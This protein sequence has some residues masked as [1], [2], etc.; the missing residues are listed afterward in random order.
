MKVLTFLFLILFS[1]TGL[2]QEEKI[3]GKIRKDPSSLAHYLTADKKSEREKVTAIYTYVTS[4]IA[5]DYESIM[6]AKPYTIGGTKDVLTSGKAISLTYCYLLQVMLHAVDIESSVISGY[7]TSEYEDSL[8]TPYKNSYYWLSV[9]IDDKWYLTDPT[10]DAGYIGLE[11]TNRDEK[12]AEK[13]DK[14]DEKYKKKSGNLQQKRE[15]TMKAGKARKLDKKIHDLDEDYATNQEKLEDDFNEADE[16][17]D[18]IGFIQEP[19]QTWFLVSPDSFLTQ[20]LPINPMWQLREDTI[21]ILE[22]MGD[23]ETRRERIAQNNGGSF[24]YNEAIDTYMELNEID[25]LIYSAVDGF[26]YNDTN[27]HAIAYNYH[28]YLSILFSKD[29]K[30]QYL[31]LNITELTKVAEKADSAAV[32]AKI[33]NKNEGAGYKYA[34]KYYAAKYKEAKTGNKY[35]TK[36]VKDGMKIHLK[37]LENLKKDQSKGAEVLESTVKKIAKYG[38]TAQSVNPKSP[39]NEVFFE[40]FLTQIDSFEVLDKSYKNQLIAWQK[41]VDTTYL[42]HAYS[43]LVENKFLMDQRAYILSY[44]DYSTND[45]TDEMDSIYSKNHE[46]LTALYQDSLSIE[47]LADVDDILKLQSRI[48]LEVQVASQDMKLKDPSHNHEL[49]MGYFSQKLMKNF[50]AF[51]QAKERS[52]EHNDWMLGIMKL[53]T[54]D[55]KAM[56]KL[57]ERQVKLTDDRDEYNRELIEKSHERSE[58]IYENIEKEAKAWE[59][60]VKARIREK[61]GD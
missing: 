16:F 31:G 32:F 18:K 24:D 26:N 5:Y 28:L 6:D 38:R 10:M 49:V 8:V 40:P 41:A 30:D 51:L 34:K 19:T 59:E 44:L 43:L 37:F 48:A 21:S 53:F 27:A 23:D 61:K 56:E 55:W 7:L 35:Y 58:A 29:F 25:Q 4:N 36:A 47:M 57:A 60:K 2:S 12:F 14:L 11:K 52:L 17:D 15:G 9:K 39:G 42:K 20:H 13:F 33:A 1:Y 54:P 46:K 50:E 45:L 3:P 22:F